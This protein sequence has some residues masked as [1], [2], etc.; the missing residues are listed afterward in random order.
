MKQTT[1]SLFQQFTLSRENCECTRYHGMQH[2]KHACSVGQ[3]KAYRP[4]LWT[5]DL[6]KHSHPYSCQLMDN[7]FCNW[8]FGFLGIVLLELSKLSLHT[9]G[10]F[11]HGLVVRISKTQPDCP[12]PTDVFVFADNSFSLE[13]SECS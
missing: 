4:L 8:T 1:F 7:F 2:A 5:L 9:E 11:L 12:L 10:W 13:R 6:Q 3:S